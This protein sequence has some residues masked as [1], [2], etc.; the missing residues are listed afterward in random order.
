[1]RH[2]RRPSLPPAWLLWLLIALLP[3]R[4]WAFGQMLPAGVGPAMVTTAVSSGIAPASTAV[5]DPASGGH[6][7][8][9]ADHAA[10]SASPPTPHCH[11]AVDLAP[12]EPADGN[13]HG[14]STAGSCGLCTVCHA[15]LAAAPLPPTLP[16]SF[17]TAEAPS[18]DPDRPLADGPRR[19]L[20][21][22]PR[23]ASL[24]A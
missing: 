8:H 3:L 9:Q 24:R 18:A 6:E 20:F 22:P 11:Q 5:H 4:G 14:K 7:A 12:A 17:L 21:R 23:P 16:L 13:H 10:L 15:G 2:A 19:A 1:M